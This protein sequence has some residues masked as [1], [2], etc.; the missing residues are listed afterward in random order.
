MKLATSQQGIVLIGSG[1]GVCGAG[2]CNIDKD[3]NIKIRN[4]TNK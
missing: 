2:G 4:N 1:P 3:S